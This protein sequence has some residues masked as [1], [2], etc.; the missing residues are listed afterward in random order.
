[1]T[2]PE[3][4]F[5]QWQ[6]DRARLAARDR[7]RAEAEK[8]DASVTEDQV[9]SMRM[10]L[11]AEL[12]RAAEQDYGCGFLELTEKQATPLV[13]R[14][15]AQKPHLRAAFEEHTGPRVVNVDFPAAP[16]TRDCPAREGGTVI[17]MSERRRDVRA[18]YGFSEADMADPFRRSMVDNI[19]RTEA[20]MAAARTRDALEEEIAA[21]GRD[22]G[23]DPARCYHDRRKVFA[24][25]ARR[26]HPIARER[27][28]RPA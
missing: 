16:A 25:L 5:K 2:S 22:L 9:N 19:S 3:Q 24:E 27:Y 7:Q 1:V 14:V 21:V 12:N 10:A 17:T 8:E 20:R 11:S 6:R 13:H 28:G 4:R 15:L 23:L 26:G 18:R